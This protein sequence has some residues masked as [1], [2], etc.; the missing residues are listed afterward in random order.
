MITRKVLVIVGATLVL[1]L[2]SLTLLAEQTNGSS[3]NSDM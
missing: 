2:C 3:S 1:A